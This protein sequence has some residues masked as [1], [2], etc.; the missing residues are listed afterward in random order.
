MKR[1]GKILFLIIS[2]ILL[3]V[4]TL[5]TNF[6]PNQVSEIDNRELNELPTLQK[7]GFRK[8]MEGYLA[9]RIGFRSDMIT[10]YQKFCDVVFHKLVH[11]SYIYGKDEHIMAPWDLVTYQ[12]LD[13]SEEYIEGFTDYVQ[14]LQQFCNKRGTEFLFYLCPNKETIYPEYFPDGYNV[15]D[16]PNRS[17]RILTRL[18][19]KKV[20][21]IYP[22]ELFLSLKDVNLLYNVKYDAGHWNHTG[23]FFGHQQIID[24]LN[25]MFPEMGELE[26]GEFEI[27]EQ[28][29]KSLLVSHFEIDEMIPDYNLLDTDAVED[30]EFFENITLLAPEEYYMYYKNDSALHEGAPKIL[31]FGDSYFHHSPKYYLNHSG[32]LMMLHATNMPNAEY[33]ISLFQPDVVIYEVVERQ[34]DS[35]WDTFKSTKRHYSLSDLQSDKAE[36]GIYLGEKLLLEIE[37]ERLQT[38][39]QNEKIISFSGSLEGIIEEPDTVFSLVAVLNEKEYY[40]I[41]DGSSL[42]YQFAF[43]AEDVVEGSEISIFVIRKI[44]DS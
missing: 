44:S 1:I 15:K 25:E 29:V 13:V 42:S 39:A 30:E 26:L 5:A 6:T 4:P 40:P 19:E 41:F 23:A 27:M 14:D 37:M 32:E 18:E 2:A 28:Q 12:H 33:Y 36:A 20:D 11:P 34:L 10:A 8:G 9:D 7:S 17:E 16:Q 21:Y 24:Y 22:K 38:Q 3:V 31:I 35:S 43:R